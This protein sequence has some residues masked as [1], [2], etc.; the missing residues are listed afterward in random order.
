MSAQ[1]L[2]LEVKKVGSLELAEYLDA[3]GRDV[4]D[5][6]RGNGS[7]TSLLRRAKL[8]PAPAMPVPGEADLLKRMHSFSH[9][10][11][12]ERVDAY[13]KFTADKA[14]AYDDL[15]EFDQTLARMLFFNLWDKAGGFSSYADGLASLHNQRTVRSELRQLLTHLER[16]DRMRTVQPLTGPHSHI[17]LSVHHAYNRSEI[18]AAMGVARLGGQLPGYFAQGVLW[19]EKNR[20]DALLITLNKSERDF[21]PTVRYKDYAL[22][23]TR[24][25]WESQNSTAPASPTGQRYQKHAE[26]G[27]HVL[28]FMRESKDTAS[29]KAMPWVLLGPATYEM[30]TGSKPMAIT[31]RLHHPL[32]ERIYSRMPNTTLAT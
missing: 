16:S 28:L 18:L 25:H 8:I 2:A 31:W 7:W 19:D 21:S 22:S 26:Q 5:V 15:T 11:D 17:P 29:G 12:A 10:D 6:Y 23:R 14:P 4:A 24:F 3:T 32:P 30:H 27:S 20:T 9:I 13:R 1:S